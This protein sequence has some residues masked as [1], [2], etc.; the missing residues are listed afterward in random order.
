MLVNMYNMYDVTWTFITEVINMTV[1]EPTLIGY[2]RKTIP[3]QG[4]KTPLYEI[5]EGI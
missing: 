2:K 3:L 4:Y 5:I 1:I